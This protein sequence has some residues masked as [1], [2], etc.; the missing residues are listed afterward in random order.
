MRFEYTEAEKKVLH[1]MVKYPTLNDRELSEAI[2]VKPSTTTAIRRRLRKAEV[3]S[4]KR[5]PMANK[6]GYELLGIFCG[7]IGPAIEASVRKTFLETVESLPQIFYSIVSSDSLFSV[8]YF[9]NFSEYR[10]FA[11]AAWEQFG[12]S[13][14]IDQGMWSW[15]VFS[16]ERAK[17]VNFFDYGPPL[18]Y[19]FDI[20]EKVHIDKSVEK[21][22]KVRLSRK[23]KIVLQGLV[24][25]PESSDKEVAERVGAS[26]QAVSAMRKRFEKTGVMKTLRVVDLGKVGYSIIALA[27]NQ[28]TPPATLESRWNYLLKIAEIIPQFL[29]VAS[30]PESILMAC[31]KD[32]EMYHSVRNKAIKLYTEKGYLREEPMLMLF[33]LSDTK[34]I[35]DFDF[36]GFMEALVQ[37]ED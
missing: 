21:P 36:S 10:G 4:T 13:D 6:L 33:P 19:I 37:E 1:G 27:H 3:F 22:S 26:R 24:N 28:F 17:M 25:F 8:G 30:N 14:V 2:G 32:Y 9:K 12:E 5:I 15:A 31:A 11:D 29:N 16:F 20:K 35:K 34:T 23:E 7:K 18:R